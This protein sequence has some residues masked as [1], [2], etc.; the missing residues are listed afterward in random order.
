MLLMMAWQRE[1]MPVLGT[2]QLTNT[3]GDTDTKVGISL[4][5]R[6]GQR[7]SAQEKF[8]LNPAL[9]AQSRT[10][11]K[12]KVRPDSSR[13]WAGKMQNRHG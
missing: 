13:R 1:R 7:Q 9:F 6:E 2:A 11:T 5:L 10:V 8:L 3:F 4:A 12:E